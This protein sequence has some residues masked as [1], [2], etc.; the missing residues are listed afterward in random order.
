MLDRCEMP[1]SKKNIFNFSINQ[2]NINHKAPGRV[3]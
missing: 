1:V 2:N 3:F